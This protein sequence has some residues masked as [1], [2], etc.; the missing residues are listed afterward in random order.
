MNLKSLEAFVEV[1][2][3]G[4]FGRAAANLGI[5]QSGL[6]Q[7]IK[8]LEKTIG[9]R[10]VDRTT[11]SF[12]LTEVGEVFLVQAQGLLHE[13][14]LVEERM[15]FAVSGEDGTVRLGFVASA[16][17]RIIPWAA[18]LVHEHAPRIKLSLSEMTSDQQL[19]QLR[20][21]EIDV[22]IMREI[23]ES[24]GIAIF[25]LTTEPLLAAVPSANLL[26]KRR[27]VQIKDL[28]DQDFIMNPRTSVSFLHDHIYR[29]CHNAGFTPRVVEQAVQFTTILGL[30]SSNAGIAIVPQSVTA[31]KLPNVSF[32]KIHDLEAVSQIYVA[33]SA[34]EKASPV[35][36][37]F[38]ELVRS[39]NFTWT[40]P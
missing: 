10:L 13:H 32:L 26:S 7:I 38:V 14:R 8:G 27:H 3:E 18:S 34:E 2:R 31:I 15:S 22:G 4:H 11:R 35:A 37:R 19:A 29:L 5:T 24:S 20:S 9:A 28:A 23:T 1:S 17:L 33:R 39:E 36:K 12:S 6:S 16:A 21:G 30:V 40:T 25:P